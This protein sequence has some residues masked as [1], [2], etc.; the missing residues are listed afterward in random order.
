MNLTPIFDNFTERGSNLGCGWQSAQPGLPLWTYATKLDE[1]NPRG[2]REP[3]QISA[4]QVSNLF[5]FCILNKGLAINWPPQL[6]AHSPASGLEAKYFFTG[7]MFSHKQSLS[8]QFS[9]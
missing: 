1:Y 3:E 8:S 2:H 7:D 4:W 5:S 6:A 9:F